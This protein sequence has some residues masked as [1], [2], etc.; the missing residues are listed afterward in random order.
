MRDTRSG[1]SECAFDLGVDP[2]VMGFCILGRRELGLD[3]GK[4]GQGGNVSGRHI[5]ANAN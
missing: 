2:C 3:G 1:G 4:F 5:R